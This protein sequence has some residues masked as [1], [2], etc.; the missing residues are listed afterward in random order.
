MLLTLKKLVLGLHRER[1]QVNGTAGFSSD[2]PQQIQEKSSSTSVML[3]RDASAANPPKST[4]EPKLALLCWLLAVFLSLKCQDLHLLSQDHYRGVLTWAVFHPVEMKPSWA[5][6]RVPGVAAEGSEWLRQP[7]ISPG[8]HIP[9][10]GSS[11]KCLQPKAAV[12]AVVSHRLG[13]DCS[14]SVKKQT[15]ALPP[16]RGV[17][18][19]LS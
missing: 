11:G 3:L 4:A 6:P 9:K 8:C 14:C 5:A 15:G 18:S 1:A 10:D 2:P 13:C 16:L 7:R 19:K 17:F 12:R